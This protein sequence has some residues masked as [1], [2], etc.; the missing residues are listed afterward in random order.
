[1]TQSRRQSGKRGRAAGRHTLPR[2]RQGRGVRQRRVRP[3]GEDWFPEQ[4]RL[5]GE[6]YVG[7]ES[8]HRLPGESW[9]QVC[10]DNSV[11]RA[12]SGRVR[13]LPRVAC[14]ASL[15]TGERSALEPPQ[16]RLDGDL[17]AGRLTRFAAADGGRDSGS[18][19]IAAQR[20]VAAAAELCRSGATR[21]CRCYCH[22]LLW[23]DMTCGTARSLLP[24]RASGVI[25]GCEA[26]VTT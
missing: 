19:D 3:A 17:K 1:M 13:R 22:A 7:K 9:I 26:P 24:G 8:Y 6:F 12:R 21:S 16:H 18:R 20:A 14:V 15:R 23:S 2:G 5:T 25:L 11:P 10:V 4:A